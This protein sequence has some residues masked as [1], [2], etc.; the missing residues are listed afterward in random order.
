LRGRWTIL[1]PN[2]FSLDRGGVRLIDPP[3]RVPD[4]TIIGD[5]APLPLGG[6][7]GSIRIVIAIGRGKGV[8]TAGSCRPFAPGRMRGK[9]LPGEGMR[10]R[11]RIA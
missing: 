3:E 11:H 9:V 8:D 10:G 2:L 5:I 6:I 1:R 4:M 7:K